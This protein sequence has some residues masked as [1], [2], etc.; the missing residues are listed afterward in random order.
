LDRHLIKG[1]LVDM[2]EDLLNALAGAVAAWERDNFGVSLIRAYPSDWEPDKLYVEWMQSQDDN[3]KGSHY[4]PCLA[5]RKKKPAVFYNGYSTDRDTAYTL[6]VLLKTIE[7]D[8]GIVIDGITVHRDEGHIS[9][10]W[11]VPGIYVRQFGNTPIA[12]AVQVPVSTE[13]KGVV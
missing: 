2:N 12:A 6:Q 7:K 11:H 9:A 4:I 3:P 8:H 5:G 13:M 10:L 1:V